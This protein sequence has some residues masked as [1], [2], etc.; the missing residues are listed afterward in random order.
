MRLHTKLSL[1]KSV[2]RVIGYVFIP[3][4]WVVGVGLLILAEII[5]VVEEIDDK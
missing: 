4:N 2:I 3:F 5:G 1:L